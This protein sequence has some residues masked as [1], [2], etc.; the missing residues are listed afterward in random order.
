MNNNE[1]NSNDRHFLSL[2]LTEAKLASEA[3]DYPVGAVLTFNGSLLDK[4]RNSLFTDKRWTAHAEHNLISRNSAYLL[5]AFRSGAPYDVCLYTTLE[6]CLMCLGVAMMHRVSR[7][8]FAC[9]EP[10]GGTTGIDPESLG[11]FYRE[12]WPDIQEGGFKGEACELIIEFLK[13][14]KFGSWKKMLVAFDGMRR[15]WALRN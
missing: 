1:C 8:V 9:P 15:G 2:A 5:N 10:H 12:E 7:I 4:D 13:T 14:G 6:P 3:G 11:M